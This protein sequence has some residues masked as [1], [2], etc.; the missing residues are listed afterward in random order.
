MSTIEKHVMATVRIIYVARLC[1]TRLAFESY[2]LLLSLIGIATL[3]SV[4][5]VLTNLFSVANHGLLGI[6]TFLLA[7]VMRTK[8]VVQVALLVGAGAL[9]LL[10]TDIIRS[11]RLLPRARKSS[12]A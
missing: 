9:L 4:P 12:L 2:A 10:S 5:H 7:A 3:V 11:L 8:I 6:G 1:T